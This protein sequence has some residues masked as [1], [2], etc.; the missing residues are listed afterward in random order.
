MPFDDGDST[1][2]P[3]ADRGIF[4]G[5]REDGDGE[6]GEKEGR[7]EFARGICFLDGSPHPRPLS[8]RERGN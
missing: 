6:E 2:L 4:D 7:V 1:F 5:E 8:Q 3:F